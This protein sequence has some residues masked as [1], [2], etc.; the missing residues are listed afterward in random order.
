[1]MA[2]RIVVFGRLH[3]LMTAT[4]TDCSRHVKTVFEQSQYFVNVSRASSHIVAWV[5]RVHDVENG[6]L[7]KIGVLEDREVEIKVLLAAA[8]LDL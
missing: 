4:V 1:M 7:V 6:L 5:E 8:W 3:S 2:V